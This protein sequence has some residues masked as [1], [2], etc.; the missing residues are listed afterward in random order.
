MPWYVQDVD[1]H[2]KGLNDEEKRQWVKVANRTLDQTGD[3][4]KAIKEANAAVDHR[5]EAQG[6]G[7]PA[8]RKSWLHG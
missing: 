5:R 6:R 4:A 3:D 7:S 8:E 1:A 2:K